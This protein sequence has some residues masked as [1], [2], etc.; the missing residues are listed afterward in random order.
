MASWRV[1]VALP[2]MILLALVALVIFRTRP[3]D[4]SF[5]LIWTL[6]AP[7]VSLAIVYLF[8][9]S[10][11]W[12]R[13]W[14][15]ITVLGL[16]IASLAAVAGIY[17]IGIRDPMYPNTS[18][19]LGKLLAAAA[20]ALAGLAGLAVH[21][22]RRRASDGAVRTAVALA[23]TWASLVAWASWGTCTIPAACRIF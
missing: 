2:S 5:G 9:V 3:I 14:F 10:A 11:G 22:Y 13:A 17:L 19:T 18:Y 20:L 12:E 15:G 23:V 4:S 7:V 16:L 21:A 6:G 1:L 8:G